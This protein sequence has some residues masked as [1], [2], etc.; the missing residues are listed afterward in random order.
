MVFCTLSSCTL[1]QAEPAPVPAPTASTPASPAAESGTGAK[2]Q[3]ATP[4]YDFGK[5]RSPEPVKYVYYFT[6]TGDAV[7]E[8]SN[9]QPQCGCTTAGDYTRKVEPGQTGTI[10][11]QFNTSAYNGQV[12]KTITVAS[13][14]KKQP[15]YVLQLKGTVWK[16]IETIP[17]YTVLNV[18]P[19]TQTA[20][21][22]VQVT[23]HLDEAL[24]LYAPEVSI[25]AVSAELKTNE[26]GKSFSV[27][28]TTVPPYSAN[29][30]SGKVTLKTSLTNM[31]TLEVP[32]WVNIQPAVSV[33]P[34][35]V[36]LQ[37]APLAVASSNV[38]RIQNSS[39]N[40]LTLSEPSVNVP[41]VDVHIKELNPGHIF[42]VV[43]G[44][45]AG[46][47][48]PPGQ[49]AMATI[50]SSNPQHALIKIP[51]MQTQR[52][53]MQAP[54]PNVQGKPT[55]AAPL[56]PAPNTLPAPAIK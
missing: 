49:Q 15:N 34:P 40:P 30:L 11:I 17:Q 52:P 33:L 43:F 56:A 31:A 48:V 27:V 4:I 46:F 44:F 12:F 18:P 47:E 14:D 8:L 19:D 26:A 35:Q 53:Q 42:E 28:L 39:S 6:N 3:F 16:P 51:I 5:A 1:L 25:S 38:I 22:T 32:F 23:N 55:A 13:N 24:E 9:V 54:V 21:I 10:P 50:K 37:Q 2:I 20:S 41:G 45:P 29:N 7:L 36:Y